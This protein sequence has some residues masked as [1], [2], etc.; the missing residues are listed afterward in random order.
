M[1]SEQRCLGLFDDRQVFVAFVVD[2][3]DCDLADL[4]RPGTGS[5]NDADQNGDRNDATDDPNYGEGD[6]LNTGGSDSGQ[7]T[8]E[9]VGKGNRAPARGMAVVP[10]ALQDEID[11]A[12]TA[13]G[14]GRRDYSPL[15]TDLINSFFDRL[16]GRSDD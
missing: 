11:D 14:R 5:G 16:S 7:G 8:G 13:T 3:V 15:V 4:L 10:P 9:T 6:E 2:D 12:G 1:I